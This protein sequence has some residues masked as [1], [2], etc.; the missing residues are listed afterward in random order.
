MSDITRTTILVAEDD[1]DD[2]LLLEEAFGDSGIPCNLVFAHDG[3]EVMTY[4][5]QYCAAP[6]R[7][8]YPSL[9]LLDLNMPRKNGE[10]VLE[11]LGQHPHLQQIPVVILSTASNLPPF[12]QQHPSVSHCFVKPS[13]YSGLVCLVRSLFNYLPSATEWPGVSDDA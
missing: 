3:E 6:Q 1:P 7:A 4:L 9:I 5:T 11:E 12:L 2:R 13:S 8:S 10:E